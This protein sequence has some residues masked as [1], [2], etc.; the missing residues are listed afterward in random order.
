M[1][2]IFYD[3]L[4]EIMV[5]GFAVTFLRDN[6]SLKFR[7][8]IKISKLTAE[9]ELFENCFESKSLREGMK[10]AW[11]SVFV[12]TEEQYDNFEEEGMI[13]SKIF[14]NDVGV[15]LKARYDAGDPPR[16][17]RLLFDAIV[18][19]LDGQNNGVVVLAPIISKL[20]TT[21]DATMRILSCL[22]AYGYMRI[23]RVPNKK[24]GQG[25]LEFEILR[26]IY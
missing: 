23:T 10:M 15:R 1:A 7:F 13:Y 22:E 26:R 6:S 5:E 14:Q 9:N 19:E 16:L 21:R 20:K 12:P 24:G 4:S 2:N 8:I 3:M 17:H 25:N 18:R 11:D